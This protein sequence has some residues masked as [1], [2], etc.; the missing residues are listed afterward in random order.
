MMFEFS[1]LIDAATQPIHAVFALTV[2]T[3]ALWW[4]ARHQFNFAEPARA[5]RLVWELLP[6]ANAPPA[7]DDDI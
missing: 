3:S 4:Q 5:E 6:P 1:A 2:L 7:S